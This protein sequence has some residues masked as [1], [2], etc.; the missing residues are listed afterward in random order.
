MTEVPIGSRPAASVKRALVEQRLRAAEA[1]SA[2]ATIPRRKDGA[3]TPLTYAQERLWFMEQF[4]PGTAAYVIPLALRLK[5][6]LDVDA[7]RHAIGVVTA[8]HDALRMR[9][10]SADDGRPFLNLVDSADADLRVVAAS[11]EEEAHAL[12]AQELTRPFDLV[13]GP[14][15]RA[16]LVTL[17]PA[18][19]VLAIPMHHIA[20]DGWSTEVFIRELT[21]TYEG[22]VNASPAI[23]ADL[24]IGYADYA[25]WQRSRADSTFDA[26]LRYWTDRLHALPP[27][28]L[29]TDRPRP[30]EQTYDGAA[31]GFRLDSDLSQAISVLAQAHGATLYMVLLAAYQVLLSRYSRQTDFAV[32]TPVAGRS[33]SELEALI[34]CFV[35]VLTMRA[36]LSGD[37]T[38]SELVFRT[39]ESALDAYSH[40]EL[41]FERLVTELNVTRDVSRPPLFQ[42]LF[43]LQ[44]Y[45]MPIRHESSGGVE[46]S[47]FPLASWATRF[48]LELYMSEDVDG[49]SGLFVYNTDL[50]ERQTVATLAGW[51][52]AL[53]GAVTTEPNLRL[54]AV[55][56]VE[57]AERSLVIDAFNDT[58]ATF[59]ADA[60]LHGLVESQIDRTP[61][62]IA[63]SFAEQS[64]TYRELGER[65]DIVARRLQQLG[66]TSE[67]LVAVSAERSL[68]LVVG[69]LGV[70]KAGAA[71]LPLDPEYPPD[72]LG[73]MLSDSGAPVILT[74]R[75]LADRLPSTNATVLYLD[76]VDSWP[77]DRP[78]PG[79]PARCTADNS[80]YAIYTSGSTGR[81]KGVANTHRGIV[82]RLTWMQKA[83]QLGPD[84]V[85]LQKTPASFDVSVW[86]FFWPLMVGARLVLAEPGGHKDAA[87]LRDLIV[88]TAVTTVHF[89]PSM[90][91]IF[92]A[93]E[94][95]NR[96]ASLRRI[97]CS[98][99]ELPVDVARR[100]MKILPAQLHNLYGPTE[101]AID[102]SAWACTDDALAYSARA[103][104]GAPIDNIKL[105]V[106]DEQLRPVPRGVPGELFIGGVGV[107]RGYLGRPSL[108]AERFLPDPFIGW[109]ARMYRTGDLA[110]WRNDGTIDFLGRID[111]QVK[112]RGLRIELGEIESVLRAISGIAEAAVVV[113]QDAPGDKRLVAY[114]VGDADVADLKGALKRELPDYM[115]PSAFVVLDHLPVSPNGKLDRTALPAPRRARDA[116]TAFAAPSTPTEAGLAEIW[117]EVIGIP[118]I[119]IDDDFF[120][121]GGHSLLATQVIARMRK[122][123][124]SGI[125][126]MD[127]FKNPTVRELGALV[128]APA[129]ARGP[130]ALLYELTKPVPPDKRTLSFVCIPYGGGSAVVYQPLADALPDGYRLFSVAIPG[131]DVGLDEAALPFDLLAERCVDEIL[132]KVDGP[133]ALYGH[134]GVG[135]ALTVEVARRV[136]AAG[137]KLDAVYIG[138]IFPFAK[139]K[140]K[141]F[142]ALSKVARM[143][144]LRSDQSYANW[145]TS[146]GV[147]MRDLEPRQ[148]RHI[149]RNMRTDSDNAEEYFTRLF[150]R[151]VAR[152]AAPI[153]AVAGDR[154]PATDFYQERYRE[155]H[156]LTERTALVVLDEAGH[157]FLKYRATELAAIVTRVHRSLDDDP[158]SLTREA[159]GDSAGWWLHGVSRAGTAVETSG[160]QPSMRRF[161]V[162]AAGQLISMTGSALTD[163]AI[164]VWI[165]LRTGSV[166][167]L[168]LLAAIALVPGMLTAPLAGAI[169]DRRNR[170]RVMMTGDCAAAGT[171]AV[172]A[173]LLWGGH[174][175]IWHLYLLLVSLSISLTFQRLAYTSAV[176]QLVPKRHLGHANGVI[177]MVTG[178]TQVTVPL[179]SVALLA[180]IGLKGIIALDL[181]SYAFAIG[182]L[183]AVR[184]P[185]TL[186]WRRKEPVT[187]EI[188]EG[189]RYSWRNRG[190][191]S[192]LFFFAALNVFLAPLFLLVTPLVLSFAT[193]GDVGRIALV[194][195]AG[196]FV[197]GLAMSVWGGPR[198]RRML[199]VMMSTVAF[200]G[201]CFVTGLRPSLPMI[202]VGAFGMSFALT[203]MNGIYTTIV[204]VKV[205]QRFHGRVFAINTVIAWSTLP[206]GWALVAPYAAK[207]LDPLLAQHGFLV[208]SI[209]RVIG[210]GAGRGVALL[211]LLFALAIAA[212]VLVSSRTR[213]LS[214]FDAEVPDA[215]ADDLVGFETRQRRLAAANSPECAVV[216][217]VA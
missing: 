53:L 17:A 67:T 211:Y 179:I 80:A 11:N 73:F 89:V 201:A 206:I 158:L 163:F 148:A 10:G 7:L 20:S 115:V 34:G 48:E 46:V 79:I 103:P 104:I 216:E 43:A 54:S 112:L 93:E 50:F 156:F 188:A 169:V 92:L 6:S 129:E 131:H 184:F 180:A 52:T 74:Q 173:A 215:I 97:I 25:A 172:L 16:L 75:R 102:V 69:L 101:A 198:R 51:L 177:Q 213:V 212:L 117:C 108:T 45:N 71:Y 21:T 202:A 87:Y 149:I 199:G 90:L 72:R 24:P 150:D 29:A 86:E 47:R 154:D 15:I 96:C 136:E 76:D 170:R 118:S 106:L 70:L 139:P 2:K 151:D 182:I 5:G 152:L 66:A 161:L 37:P 110:R 175:Q 127:L 18:D 77:S 157:F 1:R 95:V 155:W 56:A 192:M 210:V 116:A 208:G 61:D 120:D 3:E 105:Y 55:D 153:I 59:P 205:P 98:G 114:V 185:Q 38:F 147:D 19:H 31:Y 189:F 162:V 83:Y 109:G 14:L 123:F 30:L 8:R 33:R 125:S 187:R 183:F 4:A 197:A 143:E 27:L 146:M 26:D 85:V 88:A 194:S 134:C 168:G 132:A 203:L 42:V 138:A 63:V 40:Q 174:L 99:E 60:T 135:S 190:F 84:D 121:I 186:P 126:V 111:N 178:I 65:A 164:P 133:L 9:F 200:A 145:L 144:S 22:V 122:R 191:R 100:C 204:Q 41:P 57:P 64:L 91:A 13:A 128:D 124:G 207:L 196:V 130:R 141:I 28:D 119:G 62:M 166:A 159:T 39:R 49:I 23:L 209:G 78:E 58:A 32:G 140:S 81:P 160:P 193:L 68:E 176:P 165:Y 181:S 35:N 142:T 82:N 113:R 214:R 137:R 44:N 94:D 167:R 171:Q 12:V 36:D 107:A 217:E 195:G